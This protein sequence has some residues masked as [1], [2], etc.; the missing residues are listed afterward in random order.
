MA[1]TFT[2]VSERSESM[3]NPPANDLLRDLT[4]DRRLS[5]S[6]AFANALRGRGRR[7]SEIATDAVTERLFDAL[8][9]T[10]RPAA[11]GEIE[12]LPRAARPA[13]TPPRLRIVGAARD[14][15]IVVR[16]ATKPTLA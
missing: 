10:D 7:A 5:E 9:R 13:G 3:P 8:T 2:A 15:E 14:A 6:A 11:A 1:D 12:A 16:P 4:S